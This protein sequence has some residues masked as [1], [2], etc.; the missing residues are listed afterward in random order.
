MNDALRGISVGA[1]LARERLR[2]VT[3]LLVLALSGCAVYALGV[4]ERQNG[5]DGA[6]DSA[7]TGP[8]FG[9]A[10]PILAYL[11][12]ERV[13]DGQRLDHSVDTVARYGADRR[14]AVLGELLLSALATAFASVVLTLLA[15]LGAHSLRDTDLNRDLRD[16]HRRIA[17]VTGA[18][19]ALAFSAASL[20][21]KARRRAA[22]GR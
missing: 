13:C 1:A 12:S 19:Y 17:C 22:N 15:L 9:F 8:V 11:V 14:H 16:E 18:A 21:G 7:L 3:P 2:G 10:V 20:L 5:A 6:A 4:L